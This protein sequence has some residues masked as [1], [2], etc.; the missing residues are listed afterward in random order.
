MQKIAP[1]RHLWRDRSPPI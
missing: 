1:R